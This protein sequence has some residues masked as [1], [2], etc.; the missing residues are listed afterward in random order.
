MRQ[1]SL[2]TPSCS[3]RTSC[4]TDVTTNRHIPA[5]TECPDGILAVEYDDKVCDVSANLQAPAY[6]TGSDARGC[7]PRAVGESGND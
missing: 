2:N 1:R 5:N 7:R 6:A 4:G 3:N